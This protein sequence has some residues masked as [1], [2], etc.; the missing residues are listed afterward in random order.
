MVYPWTRL[1]T[2]TLPARRM[3]TEVL[4]ETTR[5]SRRGGRRST[6]VTLTIP[7]AECPE[8]K[9]QTAARPAMRPGISC[10]CRLFLHLAA[11][12]RRVCPSDRD[13]RGLEWMRGREHAVARSSRLLSAMQ[14]GGEQDTWQGRDTALWRVNEHEHKSRSRVSGQGSY[15]RGSACR[16]EAR[17]SPLPSPSASSR[18]AR[19]EV[20]AGQG[21]RASKHDAG[22]VGGG[23]ERYGA[24]ALPSRCLPAPS[25]RAAGFGC[26]H[27]K[28]STQSKARHAGAC[29]LASK[30]ASMRHPGA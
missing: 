2:L 30:P 16:K 10:A 19:H 22:S 9:R 6:H 11:V 29:M 12:P 25:C 28:Q 18:R 13:R 3:P 23:S 26:A 4:A 21:G 15:S 27:A 8:A 5:V 14:L 7:R 24:P 1:A 20:A 17:P